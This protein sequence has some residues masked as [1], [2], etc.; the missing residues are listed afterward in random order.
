MHLD[1]QGP[2]VT[3]SEAASRPPW[4]TEAP[5]ESTSGDV[6]LKLAARE[7]EKEAA[8]ATLEQIRRQEWEEDAARKKREEQELRRARWRGVMCSMEREG[9][10]DRRSI[11]MNAEPRELVPTRS[12]TF[13]GVV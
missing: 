7:K 12:P 3:Y 10:G 4:R 8:R 2:A 6:C 11:T 9:A 13:W 1:H 5:S